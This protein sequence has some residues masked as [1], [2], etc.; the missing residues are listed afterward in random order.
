MARLCVFSDSHGETGGM[1][2]AIRR[3][4]ARPFRLPIRAEKGAPGLLSMYRQTPKHVIASQCSH[5]RGNPFF[6]KKAVF[7]RLL[8]C[9]SPHQ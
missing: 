8:E 7:S 1:L 6:F 5:W 4:S 3:G 2:A 9:G